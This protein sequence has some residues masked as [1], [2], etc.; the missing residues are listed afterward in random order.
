MMNYRAYTA[1]FLFLTAHSL[2]A[3]QEIDLS[4][5]TIDDL[6]L[7][8]TLY[9]PQGEAPFPVTVLIHGA[10]QG[11]RGLA[12]YRLWV[13]RFRDAGLG[14][15]VWDKMGAG[16]SEGEYVEAPDVHIPAREVADW[17][18]L[19]AARDDVD[20]GALGVMGWSQGGWIGPLA[21]SMSEQIKYIVSVSGPS[22]SPLKQNIFDKT[23]QL[24][25]DAVTPAQA[26]AGS[27]AVRLTMTY[28]VKGVNGDSAIAAWEA[29]AEEPWFSDSYNGVPM[30]DRERALSNSRF[31]Q[32][33]VH[34]D[35][36]PYPVLT[37]LEI[38]LLAIFGGADRIVPVE[39]SVRGFRAAFE[40]SGNPGLTVRVFEGAGHGVSI[41]RDGRFMPAPG[42]VETVLGWIASQGRGTD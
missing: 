12:G 14:V 26:A 17:I 24:A 29:V 4:I 10:E 3:Q 2:A 13:D 36:E 22:V 8:G 18:E 7:A 5:R 28:L 11:H 1:A 31:Q 35:Y 23:N 25:L 27:L 20:A 41:R 33:V 6:R 39:E 42:Y 9:L 37:S 30:L 32:F 40:Q 15:F 19:L 21:A 34:N 38:P 16:E